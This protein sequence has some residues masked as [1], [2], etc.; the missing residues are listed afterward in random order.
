MY[1]CL[2]RVLY[3]G[4]LVVRMEKKNLNCGDERIKIACVDTVDDD[5]FMDNIIKK[6]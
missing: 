3:A 6:R 4:W 1:M 5:F 2:E